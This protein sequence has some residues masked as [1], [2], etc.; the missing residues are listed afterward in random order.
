[1]FQARVGHTTLFGFQCTKTMGNPRFDIFCPEDIHPIV[2]QQSAVSSLSSKIQKKQLENS[3]GCQDQ[4][5]CFNW[6][7]NEQGEL[8]EDE[9]HALTMCGRCLTKMD[10][11][12]LAKEGLSAEAAAVKTPTCGQSCFSLTN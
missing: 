12:F 2:S 11:E 9:S 5:A 1:M 7:E 6:A 4:S 10:A 8:I 3:K